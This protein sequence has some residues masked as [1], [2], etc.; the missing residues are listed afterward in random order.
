M[1]ILN[2]MKW[3]FVNFDEM[4][5]FFVKFDKSLSSNL[6]SRY[7]KFNAILMII[8]WLTKMHHYIFCITTKEDINAE[9]IVRLLINHVWKIHELSSTIVL[10]R[11]FQF[12]SLIWKTICKTLKIDI[13]L[14][15]AFHSETHNQS[16]IA[17]EK[18]KR[19]L[20]NYCNYQQNDWSEWLSIIEFEFNAVFFI[21]IKLFVFII[22]YEFKSR[23]FFD[24]FTKIRQISEKAHINA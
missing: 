2:L 5:S 21:L 14:S 12:V 18:I 17:N 4:R 15:I 20:R 6:M 19:Y 24:S 23:M 22:N 7:R 13:K 1:I 9:K 10:N 11:D 8:D 16:E 3:R